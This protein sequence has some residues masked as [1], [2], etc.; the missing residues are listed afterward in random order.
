M[1]DGMTAETRRTSRHH[2]WHISK[3]TLAKAWDDSIFS[4]SAEAGFWTCLSTP[5]LLL[6]ILGSL[7]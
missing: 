5:P 4:E 7:A 1:L 6:G 2:I 3:R